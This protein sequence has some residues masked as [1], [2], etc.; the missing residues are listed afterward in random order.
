MQGNSV[1]NNPVTEQDMVMAEDIFGKNLSHLKGKTTR[2]A[3]K[4]IINDTITVPR[5][6]CN[7][8]DVVLHINATCINGTPFLT[9]IGYPIVFRVCSSMQ[10]TLHEEHH[11][12][13]D[14]ALRKCNAARFRIKE[15]S[16]AGESPGRSG[17]CYEFCECTRPQ[18]KGRAQQ[19]NNQGRI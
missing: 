13:L 19:Q 8:K 15:N 9:S 17:R 10:G 18:T 3:P 5:E 1:R 7:R 11:E 16:C 12:V 14:R 4:A 6:L 2:R